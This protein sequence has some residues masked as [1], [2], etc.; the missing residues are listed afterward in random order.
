MVLSM[1][2][3]VRL[4]AILREKTG[5]DRLEIIIDKNTD[6]STIIRE[7]GSRFPVI[8]GFL[9]K[10]AVAVN[11]R[12]VDLKENL[13]EGDEVAILPPVSGGCVRFIQGLFEM[14]GKSEIRR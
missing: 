3:K 13:T 11:G 1:K 5:V 12:I 7:I 9:S 8:K 4:F 10:C 14:T 2:V 6:V